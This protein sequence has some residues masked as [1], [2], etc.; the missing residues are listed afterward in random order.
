MRRLNTRCFTYNNLAVLVRLKDMPSFKTG[1]HYCI[2]NP[3]M[4]FFLFDTT[5]ERYHFITDHYQR[6]KKLYPLRTFKCPGTGTKIQMFVAGMYWIHY[7]L[8]LKEKKKQKNYKPFMQIIF[9]I[10]VG[11][12]CPRFAQYPR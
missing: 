3:C 11:K 8:Y 1:D 12:I 7:C 9:S 6:T 10:K 4:I 5:F 2:E